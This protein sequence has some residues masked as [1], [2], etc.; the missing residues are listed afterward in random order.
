[1]F[2]VDHQLGAGATRTPH[3]DVGTQAVHGVVRAH[4]VDWCNRQS[5]LFRELGPE[6]SVNDC[7]A[8]I[9]FVSVHFG[10]RRTPIMTYRW[11]LVGK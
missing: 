8:G 5:S 6:K 3:N 9:D 11:P 4:R 1:M 10:V 2:L 7:N